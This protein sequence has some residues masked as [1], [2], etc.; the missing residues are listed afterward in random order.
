MPAATSASITLR[1]S[2][3]VRNGAVH[4]A[5]CGA[6][7]FRCYVTGEGLLAEHDWTTH[8]PDIRDRM[9][10]IGA[11]LLTLQTEL[12]VLKAELG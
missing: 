6:L 7:R 5:R 10:Q 3:A 12:T 2:K 4:C 8:V 9:A 11:Q 1:R